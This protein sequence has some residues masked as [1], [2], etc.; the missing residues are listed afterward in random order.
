MN[1]YS[2]LILWLEQSGRLSEP[3]SATEVLQHLTELTEC[4]VADNDLFY[5]VASVQ[6]QSGSEVVNLAKMLQ[7]LNHD[8]EAF[9]EQGIELLLTYNSEEAWKALMTGVSFSEE[10][11]HSSLRLSTALKRILLQNPFYDYSQI[12]FLRIRTPFSDSLEG[13]IRLTGLEEL[14]L[15]LECSSDKGLLKSL[16]GL[17]Q[18]PNLKKLTIYPKESPQYLTSRDWTDY[19]QNIEEI[20]F[21]KSGYN[22]ESVDYSFVDSLPK[23]KRLTFIGVPIVYDNAKFLHQPDVFIYS[24]DKASYRDGVFYGK[25]LPKV[26]TSFSVKKL[27]IDKNSAGE[28]LNLAWVFQSKIE[29]LDLDEVQG[30]YGVHVFQQLSYEPNIQ[31]NIGSTPLRD[32]DLNQYHKN[33]WPYTILNLCSVEHVMQ[34]LQQTDER[35]AILQQ[36]YQKYS[37]K[38]EWFNRD[39]FHRDF[40]YTTVKELTIV[41]PEISGHLSPS[42]YHRRFGLKGT[43]NLPATLEKIQYGKNDRVN[44]LWITGFGKIQHLTELKEIVIVK[45]TVLKTSTLEILLTLP[46]LEKVLIVGGKPR[47]RIP[48]KLRHIVEYRAL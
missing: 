7:L 23:L 34:L 6:Q 10:I 41:Y 2:K 11:E 9:Q 28:S 20:E 36:L 19:L 26:Q 18:L 15:W 43:Q 39:G 22:I 17:E 16:K 3:T 31:Y 48:K 42:Y 5:E 29:A 32:Y 30:I 35:R 24:K 44:D 40:A 1:F 13:I 8:E 27:Y 12:R 37:Q 4:F 25:L 14:E 46:K 45:P 21:K 33:T 38:V 47:K